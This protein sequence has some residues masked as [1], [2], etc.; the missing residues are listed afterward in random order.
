MSLRER[1]LYVAEHYKQM[2]GDVLVKHEIENMLISGQHAETFPY[3]TLANKNI[4]SDVMVAYLFSEDGQR[5]YLVMMRG[6]SEE[7]T[8]LKDIR[9]FTPE[10]ARVLKDNHIVIGTSMEAKSFEDR[11]ALYLPY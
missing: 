8:D 2:G 1:L 5:I 11:V 6:D 4:E 3:V 10:H 9:F 7:G